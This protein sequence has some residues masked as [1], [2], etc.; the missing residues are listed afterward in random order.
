MRLCVVAFVALLLTFASSDG[1]LANGWND[2][3]AIAVRMVGTDPVPQ[4]SIEGRSVRNV[5]RSERRRR[6]ARPSHIPAA[7]VVA[8]ARPWIAEPWYAFPNHVS[9]RFPSYGL[10]YGPCGWRQPVPCVDD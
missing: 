5:G 9:V 1:V 8:F 4:R 3:G 7:P 2:R 6:H 10:A